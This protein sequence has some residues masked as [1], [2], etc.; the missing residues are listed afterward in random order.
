MNIYNLEGLPEHSRASV[1]RT[2][3]RDH[4]MSSDWCPVIL[5]LLVTDHF[6]CHKPISH[7][8]VLLQSCKSCIT[9]IILTKIDE[10]ECKPRNTSIIT[11][12]TIIWLWLWTVSSVRASNYWTTLPTDVRECASFSVFKN[13]LKKWIQ[14]IQTCNHN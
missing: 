14:N 5:L 12:A 6:R 10:G 2:V 11:G 13:K 9:R 4:V 8:T 3:C 7:D 1:V